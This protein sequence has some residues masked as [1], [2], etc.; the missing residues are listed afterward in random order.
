MRKHLIIPV[1]ANRKIEKWLILIAYHPFIRGVEI[2]NRALQLKSMCLI[3]RN[4][5]YIGH[6]LG[7][8]GSVILGVLEFGISFLV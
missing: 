6:G 1:I 2:P 5:G 7:D 8:M 4:S 3:S